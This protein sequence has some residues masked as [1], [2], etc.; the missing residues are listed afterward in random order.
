MRIFRVVTCFCCHVYK[1]GRN[2]KIWCFPPIGQYSKCHNESIAGRNIAIIF[3][4]NLIALLNYTMGI[5]TVAKN[6]GQSQFCRVG[7]A[8]SY[9]PVEWKT[10]DIRGVCR[11]LGIMSRMSSSHQIK[12]KIHI[13]TCTDLSVFFLIL[14]EGITFNNKYLNCITF[15]LQFT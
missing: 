9:R 2:L 1:K 14:I 6:Y 4:S 10:S 3:F 8:F 5:L 13:N 12:G 15:Y 7:T 11:M